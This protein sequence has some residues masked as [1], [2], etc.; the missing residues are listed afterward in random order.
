MGNVAAS[1]HILFLE[2]F[3]QD[4]YT[5]APR[6][7]IHPRCHWPGLPCVYRGRVG[8]ADRANDGNSRHADVVLVTY[9]LGRK[10][11]P[12]KTGE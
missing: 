4:L 11:S 1:A 9:L 12:S 7:Y 6:H 3:L 8:N 10:N 5:F 2:G